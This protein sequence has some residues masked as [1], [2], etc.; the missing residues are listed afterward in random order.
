MYTRTHAHTHICIYSH[1]KRKLL[2]TMLASSRTC[3]C[4]IRT[5]WL[6]FDSEYQHTWLTRMRTHAQI[7]ARWHI[8]CVFVTNIHNMHIDT[9]HVCLWLTFTTYISTHTMR[10]FITHV[11]T[12]VWYTSI[13]HM[14]H[15][16]YVDKRF[17]TYIPTHTVC[18]CDWH[19]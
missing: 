9:Y 12:C 14:I 2:I 1:F 8:P 3:L 17:T 10:V 15:I 6:L 13:P 4:V 19:S 5:H 18:V 16:I 7:Y 11:S